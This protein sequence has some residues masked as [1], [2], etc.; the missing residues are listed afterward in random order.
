MS[1][2]PSWLRVLAV[3]FAA[4][5]SLATSMQHVRYEVA[6]G[7]VL[8]D[9]DGLLVYV[10]ETSIMDAGQPDVAGSVA[11]HYVVKNARAGTVTFSTHDASFALPGGP[12]AN[13]V[14]HRFDLA[15]GRERQVGVH[16]VFARPLPGAEVPARTTATLGHATLEDGRTVGVSV[17]LEMR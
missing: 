17:E 6:R 1:T 13:A 5:V 14:P 8:F 7:R 2:P 12:V 10:N 3:L 16:F 4:V 11:V 9:Q 15:P